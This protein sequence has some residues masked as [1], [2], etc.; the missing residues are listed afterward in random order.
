MSYAHYLKNGWVMGIIL[1][2][3]LDRD[4]SS[5]RS[6]K[7]WQHTNRIEIGIT[8]QSPRKMDHPDAELGI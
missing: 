4:I 3:N 6:R 5:Q 1:E 7:F 8:I 2:R